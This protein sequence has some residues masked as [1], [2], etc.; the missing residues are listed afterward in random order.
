MLS[1]GSFNGF[2]G[3]DDVDAG[4]GVRYGLMPVRDGGDEIDGLV[5]EGLA[6]FN[7]GAD[8]VAVTDEEL[9]F[10]ECARVL[11]ADSHAFLEDANALKVVEII[12]DEALAAADG[13]NF[14]DFVRVGPTNVDIADDF[15]AVAERD[16]ANVFSR[17]T[18]STRAN[19]AGPDG[20]FAEE[21][22][23]D[24]DIVRGQIPDGVHVLADGTKIRASGVKVIHV[25]EGGRLHA[26]A[27]L[28]DAGIVEESVGDHESAVIFFCELGK[29][30]AVVDFEGQRLFDEDVAARF[31]RLEG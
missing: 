4:G 19:G 24:R 18:E 3:A 23:E 27:H 2:E 30:L 13:D 22:V 26:F 7:L 29:F 28:A 6:E 15:G 9:E 8:D 31:E 17:V 11:F 25:A 1:H 10:A 12:E 16:E 21:V 14:A 20:R 5:F